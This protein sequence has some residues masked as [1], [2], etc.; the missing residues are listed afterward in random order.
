MDTSLLV[1]EMTQLCAFMMNKLGRSSQNWLVVV[2]VSQVTE[3]VYSASNTTKKTPTWSSLEVG[4]WPCLFGILVRMRLSDQLLDLTF[5]VNLSIFTTELSSLDLTQLTNSFNCGNFQPVC[6]WTRSD[7]MRDFNRKRG[8]KLFLP[9]FRKVKEP[10]LLQ[11]EV[12]T[13]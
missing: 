5:A 9:N 4:I 13:V 3:I 10:W 8:Q 2:E 1:R 7:G 6:H 11:E 12:Q